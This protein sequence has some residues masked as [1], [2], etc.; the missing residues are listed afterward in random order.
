MFCKHNYVCTDWVSPV[1]RDQR[2]IRF[3][4]NGLISSYKLSHWCW[5]HNPGPLSEQQL[6][7]ALFHLP[8][9][10]STHFFKKFLSF[11]IIVFLIYT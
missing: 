9:L 5:K 4:R 2:C 7:L 10:I 1:Y 3:S 8:S 6:L 11:S